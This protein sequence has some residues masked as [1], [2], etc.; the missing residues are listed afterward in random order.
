MVVSHLHCV[1]TAIIQVE[2][3]KLRSTLFNPIKIYVASC[4]N[5]DIIMIYNLKEKI[6]ENVKEKKQPLYIRL[7]GPLKARMLHQVHRLNISQNT[8]AKMALVK[9]LE[10]EEQIE[11]A[12][13]KRS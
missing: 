11:A 10:E 8:L 3:Q 1:K 9:L 13:A 12:R 5:F 6:M 4:C 2:Q 7:E